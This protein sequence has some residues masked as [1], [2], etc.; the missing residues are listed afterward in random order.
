MVNANKVICVVKQ[1]WGSDSNEYRYVY[2]L[3]D[4]EVYRMTHSAYAWDEFIF[5]ISKIE[6]MFKLLGYTLDHGF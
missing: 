3:G 6:K 5:E 4:Q 2:M 1:Q